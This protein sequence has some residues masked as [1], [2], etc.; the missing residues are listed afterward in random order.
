MA[1]LDISSKSVSVLLN[2]DGADDPDQLSPW[3]PPNCSS[4]RG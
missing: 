1:Y 2:T 3:R 4:G